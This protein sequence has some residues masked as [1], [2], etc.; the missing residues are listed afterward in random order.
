M[1]K[2]YSLITAILI[3]S[4]AFINAQAP[5]D[6]IHVQSWQY[7]SNNRDTTVNFPSPSIGYEKVI[8]RYAM[9]CKG[10]LV[11][12]GT[13]RNLGCGEWDYSC[14]TYI[15]NPMLA[16]SL[17]RT[18][19]RYQI[20]PSSSDSVYSISPTYK[21][22]PSIQ[23]NVQ[24]N[25]ITMEDTSSIGSQSGTSNI[26]DSRASNGKVILHYTASELSNGGLLAGT[27]D[28]I[29]L[30][31][32]TS[33]SVPIKY[34]RIGMKQVTSSPF[35]PLDT[36]STRGF[37]EVYYRDYT[38]NQGGNRIQFHSPLIWNGTSDILIEIS[39]QGNGNNA[40]L[41]LQK[42]AN[43]SSMIS[44]N[45]HSLHLF[46]NNYIEANSYQVINGNNSRTVEA[47]IKTTSGGEI[48]SWGSNVTGGKQS[49]R[50][51]TGSGLIRLEIN[52]GYI[53]GSTP[54]DDGKWHH[55]AYTFSG[56]SLNNV[57]LYVDGNLET[58]SSISSIQMN[59]VLSLPLQISK[60]FHNRYFDGEIDQVRIWSAALISGTIKDWMYRR[61]EAPH[62][63]MPFLQLSYPIDTVSSTIFDR[64]GNQRDATFQS[65]NSFKEIGRVE[66]FKD[67]RSA[68]GL[69]ANLYQG[70]YNLTV[71]ND[72]ITDSIAQAPIIVEERSIV[73]RQGTTLTDSIDR[74][75]LNYYPKLNENYDLNGN[76]LSSSISTS[77]DTLVQ[78]SLNYYQRN[79]Q[80]VE[81][82]SFVTP[83]GINL[84][85]GPNG[86]YW[87]FDVTDF[88]PVL[89]GN[90]RMTM[91]RGG[92]WQEEMDIQF[93]FIVGTPPANVKSIQEVW[94]VDQRPY[95]S[96]N[97]NTYFAPRNVPLDT[98]ARIFKIRSAIT[99]HG[100]QG[101]F[102]QR[103]HTITANTTTSFNRTV[104]KECAE[105]PVYPQGGT[106][107]YDRAGWC[108]GM[109]TDVAEYDISNL[110]QGNQ[111]VNL[112]YNVSNATGTSN[113]IVS[114]QLVQYDA[115]NFTNDARIE[116]ILRP[117]DQTEFGRKNP[118]CFN[119]VVIIRN[120]GSANL[121]AANIDLRINGGSAFSFSWSGNLPFMAQ[122]NVSIPVPATFWASANLPNNI[123]T[124]TI[125]GVN[126]GTDQYIH[127]NVYHSNFAMPDTLPSTFRLIIKTNLR[128]QENRI[129]I[130]NSQGTVAFTRNTFPTN[131]TTGNVIN[132]VDGCYQLRLYDNGDD[133]LS[134]FANNAGNGYFRIEDTNFGVLK[135]FNPDFG[136]GVE[137][138][139]TIDNSSTSLEE[140]VLHPFS[141]YP[142]PANDQ[143]NIS[144][145]GTRY[146]WILRNSMGQIVKRRDGMNTY[147]TETLNLNDLS[148]GIYYL[149]IEGE[150]ESLL[151]KVIKQ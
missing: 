114:T 89:Q 13:N 87:Y 56:S 52:G 79:P 128:P 142:N 21:F 28:A 102:I 68:D 81:I 48:T 118:S 150:D 151:R 5:G 11:S 16:D 46:P 122:T 60:G 53:I 51:I 29:E 135:N 4:P 20:T 40:S 96:I 3:L 84:D 148:K 113:Y 63:Y 57:A 15:H 2:L 121:T 93:Y 10:G 119:P 18:I 100:Q 32:N 6:T 33:S 123:M 22:I 12:S 101:E 90:R 137:Y 95:S 136:D 104:W 97:N 83:Y 44:K 144:Y 107:V 92:Q 19:D 17:A 76:L 72:T 65:T 75:V 94:K 50:V 58:V 67:F 98:S 145:Q 66:L 73:P 147:S 109:A 129:T 103:T 132:L 82:M 47:W 126:N 108:P 61:A 106:W 55:V 80:K 116:N 54:V 134:F 140:Q 127:N 38:F 133:G 43:G 14:N 131:S 146:S 49:F 9:R 91:E 26:I 62:P 143:L 115:P 24:L 41:D 69:V 105:N 1:R 139:F 37:Q 36:N 111:S 7:S 8:M 130:V 99:G 124:A 70:T 64:S 149:S 78:S 141:L 30:F 71:S 42:Y 88:L 34:M 110:A 86:K 85:L 39:Y 59:T 31:S 77:L 125:T 120:T 35:S 45:D 27:I 23:K 74:Q 138:Y 112:D 25:S 117:N